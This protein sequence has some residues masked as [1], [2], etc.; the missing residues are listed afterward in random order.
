M[1]P[2]RL[3]HIGRWRNGERRFDDLRRGGNRHLHAAGIGPINEDAERETPANG[4]EGVLIQVRVADD[5]PHFDLGAIGG[6]GGDFA[7]TV[8]V[9]DGGIDHQP[10]PAGKF[11]HIQRYLQVFVFGNRQVLCRSHDQRRG[12]GRWCIGEAERI[13]GKCILQVARRQHTVGDPNHHQHRECHPPF[14]HPARLP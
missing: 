3:A 5:R 8:A 12:R 6:I 4:L 2:L 1:L 9:D 10:F 14:R 11:A 7:L 13:A